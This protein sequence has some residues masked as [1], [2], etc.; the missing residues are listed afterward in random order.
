MAEAIL[1]TSFTV[2][3]VLTALRCT[4]EDPEAQPEKYRNLAF[5]QAKENEL[6]QR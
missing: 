4:V 2:L 3:A 6:M 1:R 5:D